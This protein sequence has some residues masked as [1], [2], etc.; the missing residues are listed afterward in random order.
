M[1]EYIVNV[2]VRKYRVVCLS[3]YV[4]VF[5]SVLV[6]ARDSILKLLGRFQRDFPKTVPYMS[7]GARF[8]FGLISI[9]YDVTAIILVEK[10]GCCTLFEF[11]PL[12]EAAASIARIERVPKI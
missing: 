8:L 6:C 9:I 4:S 3:I 2:R 5:M 1:T 12:W 7:N 11:S 10:N